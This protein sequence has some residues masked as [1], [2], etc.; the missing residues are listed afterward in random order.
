MPHILKRPLLGTLDDKGALLEVLTGFYEELVDRRRDPGPSVGAVSSHAELRR[1]TGNASGLRVVIVTGRTSPLD[2][3][4]GAYVWDPTSA[5]ADND[6]TVIAVGGVA[7]G[8]WR[9]ASL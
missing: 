4:E 7:R 2:G 3:G 8:R 1:T 5:A 9:K 6:T